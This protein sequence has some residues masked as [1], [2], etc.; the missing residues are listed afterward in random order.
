M[1]VLFSGK[2]CNTT[3]VKENQKIASAISRKSR[4]EN[5]CCILFNIVMTNCRIKYHLIKSIVN[6]RERQ[7][8][9]IVGEH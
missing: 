5:L 9:S 1:F 4:A 6:C 2:Y 8:D 7:I 3:E